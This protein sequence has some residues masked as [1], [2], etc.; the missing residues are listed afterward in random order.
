MGVA[1]GRGIVWNPGEAPV[2]GATDFLVMVAVAGLTW[3][4][5]SVE[6]AVRFLGMI[7][8]VATVM[9]IYAAIRLFHGNR[10]YAAVSAA[11]LAVGPGL[12]YIE[13]HFGTPM[14]AFMAA[15]SWT[16][17]LALRSTP[18]S[19]PLAVG[20]ALTALTMGLVRPEG[21]L[22]AVFMLAGLVAS[23]GLRR[24]FFAVAAFTVVFGI[25]G[26]GYFL[27]RWNY[28]GHPLPNPFYV[29]GGGDLHVRHLQVAV[30]SVIAMSFPFTI[31]YPAATAAVGATL[32]RGRRQD[33]SRSL[34]WI[35][36]LLL[37]A[38]LW[39]LFRTSKNDYDFLVLGRYSPR[40][41]AMLV[42]LVVAGGA[43]LAGAARL[44]GFVDRML[45]RRPEGV[46]WLVGRGSHVTLV[47]IPAA[48][49]TLMWVLLSDEMN[50]FSRFQYAVLP[51]LLVSWPLV[52]RELLGDDRGRTAP[53]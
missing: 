29:K 12:R 35:G 17:I 16:F 53:A 23:R 27:W 14:F 37:A 5:Q 31:V 26:G 11:F 20:F 22:F 8:H 13:A 19:R 49:F 32:L 34:Q 28:F 15:L 24:C 30:S 39:G 9:L 36:C 46:R 21:V 51:V 41:A 1:A 33:V 3:L 10:F 7:S 47:L 25:L 43:A 44:P 40:Y 38:A 45:A 42:A 18:D 2:D 6:H 48:G 4:G 50:Y 52:G